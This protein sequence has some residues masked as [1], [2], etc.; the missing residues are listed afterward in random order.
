VPAVL[1]TL[2]ARQSTRRYFSS[3]GRH[4]WPILQRFAGNERQRS[5]GVCTRRRWLRSALVN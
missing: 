1:G 2:Q 3:R 5:G 4:Y